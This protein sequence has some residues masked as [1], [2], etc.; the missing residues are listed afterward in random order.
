MASLLLLVR[1]TGDQVQIFVQR[2]CIAS[3]I[4]LG[5][6]HILKASVWMNCFKLSQQGA[7]C[8]LVYLFQILYTFRV[9]MCPSSEELLYLCDTGIFHCVWVA[10]WTGNCV[11]II[12]RT[13]CIYATLVFFTLYG[14]LS[15]LATMCP[16]KENLLYLCDTCVFHCVWVAAW[17]GN[18][19]SS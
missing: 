16:H 10:A 1:I 13:N 4:C 15:G 18:Y 14:W 19:V 9:T 2:P 12:R 5:F 3:V 6:P 8:F 11:S 7:H 17:T